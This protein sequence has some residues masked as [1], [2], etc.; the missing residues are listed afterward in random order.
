VDGIEHRYDVLRGH[1]GHDIV[2][3]LEHKTASRL[4]DGHATPDIGGDLLRCPAG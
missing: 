2:N 3:L 1:V 4:E